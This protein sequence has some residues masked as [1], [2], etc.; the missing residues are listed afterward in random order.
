MK[1][2]H[3]SAELYPYIKMGGLSDML[4]S[5]AKEQAKENEVAVAIPLIAGLKTPAKFT[6]KTYPCIHPN[7]VVGSESSYILRDSVFR[8][9]VLGEVTVFFFDSPLFRDLERIYENPDEHY[10]FALFS[11]ACFVR[12]LDWKADI[13]H[14]HDWHTALNCYFHDASV[15]GLPTVFTIHNLAYQGDHPEWLCGFLKGEP[16]YLNTDLLRHAGK[17]NY[18]KGAISVADR[19]TTVSPGYRDEVLW[20]PQGCGL[21]Y[22]LRQRGSHFQGILNGLDAEE[23]NPQSD[24]HI[25]KHYNIHTYESGKL[26]NKQALYE[27]LGRK[28]DPSR[29]VV[30]L[31]GRLTGQKG[32]ETFLSSFRNK[33]YHPFFYIFLGSGDIRLEGELFHYSHHAQ[34]RIFFEKGYNEG[35]AH[36]IEAASDFFLMPSLF[37]P[38]G[39]NQMYSQAYGSIP[40]VSRVGGLKDTVKEDPY[41]EEN[42][43]GLLFEPGLSHSLDFALDRA[44]TLYQ[45]KSRLEGYRKRIMSLDWTWKNR[46]EE[47]YSLY[48]EILD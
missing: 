27:R 33:W 32:Y 34:D 4:A 9:A 35:L 6:G 7:A 19:V 15:D 13:V 14:A 43:T 36:L 46:V 26:A 41:N 37:E 39:L 18:M 8:E 38:C 11:Y 42:S 23:W 10:R 16:F 25:A 17:I 28:I 21:S 12:S 47:Y 44:W 29:P 31:I 3:C 22:N 20:E 24:K 5:L 1:I 45:N 2:F 40:I 30:G 48:G